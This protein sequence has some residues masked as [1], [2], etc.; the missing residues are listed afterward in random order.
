VIGAGQ[1]ATYL[2]AIV[3][4]GTTGATI[5]GANNA[6]TVTVMPTAAGTFTISLTTTDNNNFV[7]TTTATVTV[8][9]A[10]VPPSSSGGGGGGGALGVGWLTLLLSAVLA[11]AGVAQLERRRA[12]RALS[13]SARA[14]R[15]R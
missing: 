9:A 3:S 10:S 13:G 12:A 7:S 8:A 4:A 1:S 15:R 14:V 6:D 2:W 5:S 11:L